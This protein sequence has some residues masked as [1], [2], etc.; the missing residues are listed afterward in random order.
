MADLAGEQGHHDHERRWSRLVADLGEARAELE[1]TPD[2]RTTIEELMTDPR[3]LVRLWSAS[4]VLRWDEDRARP[5]L[6]AIR[7]EPVRYDLLSIRAKHTLLEYD[8][9]RLSADGDLPGT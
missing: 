4:A 6:E 1:T 2:G 8:A 9:G 3:P 7:E 5:T